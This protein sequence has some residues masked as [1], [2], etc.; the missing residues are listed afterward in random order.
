MRGQIRRHPL[1]HREERVII[2]DENL[3]VIAKLGHFCRRPD[4]IRDRTRRP[5][6]DEDVKPVFPQVIH[7]PLAD[8]AQA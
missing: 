1:H 2:R 8:N 3:D 6:P 5:V 4:K 7:D